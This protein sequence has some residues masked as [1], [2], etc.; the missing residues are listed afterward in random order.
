MQKTQTEMDGRKRKGKSVMFQ[1]LKKCL[2]GKKEADEVLSPVSGSV[3]P[4]SEVE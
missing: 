1:T 4:L 3:V 2:E